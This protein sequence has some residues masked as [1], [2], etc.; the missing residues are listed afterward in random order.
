MPGSS[1][2][3]PEL[4][5]RTARRI[6]ALARLRWLPP[7]VGLFYAR[8]ERT[9]RQAGDSFSVDSAARPAELGDLLELARGRLRVAELGTGTAWTTIALALAEPRRTVVSFDPIERPE[10]ELYL[11]LVGPDVLWRVRLEGVEGA[12]GADRA[13]TVDLLFIDSS[14]EREPTLAELSAWRPKL[15]PG[16]LVVFHDYEHP[17]YPGVTEA[18]REL[19]LEGDARGGVFVWRAPGGGG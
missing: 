8:A 19:G 3:F 1:A 17:E 12:A 14:H 13:G 18:I 7:R 4:L 2:R 11:G 6:R 5:G 15:A 9:A 10:R 16:A